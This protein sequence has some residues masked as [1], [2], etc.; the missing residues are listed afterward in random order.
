MTVASTAP[1]AIVAAAAMLAASPAWQ[2][3]AGAG[4]ATSSIYY[5]DADEQEAALPL[6]VL[7]PAARRK[8]KF[9]VGAPAM[10]GGE[11]VLVIHVP[12]TV[13]IESL[14]T[15]AE[16]ICK[17]MGA[18]DTGLAIQSI[19]LGAGENPQPGERAVNDTDDEQGSRSITANIDY[20]LTV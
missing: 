16:A 17:E 7:F 2:T 12:L 1:P 5:P 9:I 18:M 20:G 15:T 11:L 3:L 13:T 19:D 14:E 10:D 6:A 8:R 4:K